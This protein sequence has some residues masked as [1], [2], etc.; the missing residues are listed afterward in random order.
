MKKKKKKVPEKSRYSN[1]TRLDDLGLEPPKIYRDAQRRPDSKNVQ[2]QKKDVPKTRNEKR[3][4]QNKK[5]KKKNRFRRVLI[6]MLVAVLIAAVLVVLSLTVFFKIE[7]ITV[8]GNARYSSDQILA[9]CTIDKDENLFLADVSKSKETLEQTLPYI[10]NV[11]IKRK[12][13]A[14][15]ELNITECEPSFY[16]TN[17]DETFLLLDDNLKVLEL[18]AVEKNGIEIKSAGVDSSSLAGQQLKVSDE[19][20]LECIQKLCSCVNQNHFDKITAV[21]SNSLTDNY[22]VYDNRIQFKLGNC[23]DLETKIYQALASCEKLEASDPNA[24]GTMTVTGGK[25]I[26]FTEELT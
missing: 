5:R 14:T 12:L 22:V 18:N 2:R 7:T 1:Q 16:I 9:Q 3:Q 4:E 24:R 26:Y 19:N 6:W 15:I 23:S 21:Y 8:K 11:D 10:Y 17:E 25:Q 20:K 13:P